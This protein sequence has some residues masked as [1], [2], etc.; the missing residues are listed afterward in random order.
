MI[1][2]VN[3]ERLLQRFLQYVQIGTAA[4]PHSETYPSSPQQKD[5]S[6]VLAEQLVELG[7]A[8]AHMDD[9]GLVWG[10]VPANVA[11]A[12]AIALNSHV[13]TSPEAPGDDVKPQVIVYQGGDIPLPEDNQVI[14]VADCPELADLVGKTLITTDGTTLLGGD[15]KAGV[16]IIMELV[17]TLIENPQ[18]PH[19]PVKILF[20]CDEEIGHGTDK[21]D[22][23][24]LDAVA[25]YTLDGGGAGDLDVETFSADGVRV[26]F[27]GRNIHPS[28]GKGRMVNA[29]RAAGFFLQQL[30]DD[31]LSPES[32]DGR[33]G[34]IHPYEI[35]GGVGRAELRVLLRS[36]D[37][38]ELTQYA[39][40]LRQAATATEKQYPGLAV[41]VEVKPQYRN[42]ADGL[43]ENPRVADLAEQAFRN[44]GRPVRRSII[45]G[46]TDG[47][48]L[49]EKGLPTP[50]LSSGQHAIHSLHEFACLEEMIQAVEHLQEL[51]RLWSE[52]SA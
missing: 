40:R 18:L 37:T 49:T 33:D 45:R 24:Q 29:T 3:R 35:E 16:A 41:R 47:S 28:I 32:T 50:N 51:L 43:R 12:S 23:A 20:S 6:R 31:S 17:A 39:D 27:T 1:V 14:R 26:T 21:I 11:G 13:D 52:V 9:H 10:T 7:V 15:D 30:P 34:F 38:A 8:D 36:F 46:G 48:A 44:L 5:L 22:L 42:M 25:A 4:D 19:G 2:P